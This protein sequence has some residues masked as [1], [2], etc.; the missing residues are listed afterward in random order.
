MDDY[1]PER[2]VLLKKQKNT[3][4]FHGNENKKFKDLIEFTELKYTS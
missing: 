2:D 3:L 1:N 4:G